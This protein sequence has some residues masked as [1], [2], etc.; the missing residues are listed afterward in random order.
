MDEFY[1]ELRRIQKKERSNGT[2][3]RVEETFY[4]DIHQYLDELRQEAI[5][6]PFNKQR[7]KDAGMNLLDAIFGG[8]IERL[9][10]AWPK[11]KEKGQEFINKFKE[12]FDEKLE[13]IKTWV[14]EL[15]GKIKEWILEKWSDIKEAG[16][17]IVSG[18][19]QGIS[20][21]WSNLGIVKWFKGKIGT[22]TSAAKNELDEHSPSRVFAEIGRYIDEGLMVGINDYYDK[23]VGATEDLGDGAIDA[24]K[25]SID[26]MSEMN[27]EDMAD[28]VI[29][30]VLDLSEIQNGR[31]SINDLLDDNYSFGISNGL[32]SVGRNNNTG[33]PIINMTIN[34]S[35]GQDVEE[36][37]NIIQHKINVS[38][39]SRNSVWGTV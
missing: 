29:K 20:E 32:T 31:N 13:S 7:M 39:R 8:F 34:A 17:Q 37:A 23:V 36:L 12:G 19:K 27:L 18:I 9:K 24:M 28:P 35:E 33:S 16:G 1:Q 38:L 10:E 6:D 30:P 2:L 26:A 14:K 15:P 21:W 25:D 22:L 5:R 4:N 3:A 11:I